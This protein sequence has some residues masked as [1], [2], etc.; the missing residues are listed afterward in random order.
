MGCKIHPNFFTISCH[1]PL[2]IG[3]ACR[4]LDG[5]ERSPLLVKR[6]CWL[7]SRYSRPANRCFP[8]GTKVHLCLRP[9]AAWFVGAWAYANEQPLRTIL[10]LSLDPSTGVRRPGHRREWIADVLA[11]ARSYIDPETY[12]K[13]SRALTPHAR[14][15]PY[16]RY[17]RHCRCL[18]PT[19]TGCSGMEC[20]DTCRGSPQ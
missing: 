4:L 10:R 9:S 11:L 1:N 5:P 16:R 3:K 15:R 18:S 8:P 12:S 17:E 14:H 13:L 7:R 20:Q 6:C 2:A 19:G